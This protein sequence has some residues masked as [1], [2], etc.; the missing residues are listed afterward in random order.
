MVGAV[1]GV[2]SGLAA[3]GLRARG[4]STSQPAVLEKPDRGEADRRPE[5]VDEAGDEQRDAWS[6]GH[7]LDG[8]S[9]A[10]AA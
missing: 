10:A 8:G 7:E 1:A 5:Q 3:A 6:V 4:T 9:E 2:E